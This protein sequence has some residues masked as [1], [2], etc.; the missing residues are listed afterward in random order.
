MTI[1]NFK[2]TL[3]EGAL[4]S[5]FHSVSIADAMA[6]KP[7]DIQGEKVVFTK[8]K[9]GAVNDYAG[10]VNWAEVDTDIVEM[11]FP[12]QKYFAI[13]LE[14]DFKRVMSGEDE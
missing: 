12:K 11:P 5:Q 14:K 1:R 3:W 4:L 13:K 7:T 10:S 6:T 8:V 9:K 2:P